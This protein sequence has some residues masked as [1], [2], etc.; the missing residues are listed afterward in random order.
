MEQYEKETGKYAI[1]QGKITEGFKL[2][3]KGEY[4]NKGN[5]ERISVYITNENKA[6]WQNFAKIHNFSTIS[7]LIREGVD[8]FINEKSKPFNNILSTLDVGANVHVSHK[9][10]ERLTTIKGYL[11]LILEQYNENL[12]DEIISIMNEI[13]IETNQ[14]EKN[15]INTFEKT[16]A[17]AQEYDILV[18]EDDLSTINL[19]KNYFKRKGYSCKGALTGSKGFE[20]FF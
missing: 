18:I 2:W 19:L 17:K 14:L 1:W 4:D 12:S 3:K 5:K 7:K 8:F 13:L 15:I 16:E 9:L 11:Q 6:K 20:E 10:K